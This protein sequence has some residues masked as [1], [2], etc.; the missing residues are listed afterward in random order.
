M[1][2]ISMKGISMTIH[3]RV[4]K[5]GHIYA[6]DDK[7]K[8]RIKVSLAVRSSVFRKERLDY[9]FS[10]EREKLLQ[11]EQDKKLLSLDDLEF[12]GTLVR[13]YKN[14]K[15]YFE[16]FHQPLLKLKRKNKNGF[17]YNRDGQEKKKYKRVKVLFKAEGKNFS[18]VFSWELVRMEKKSL[19]EW[20]KS[21]Y[22]SKLSAV[23]QKVVL[24][25]YDMKFVEFLGYHA[26]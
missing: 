18:D 5:R 9:L 23:V 15:T 19:K 22:D 26:I 13:V 8:K 2:H 21:I 14:K 7:K 10:I 4:N 25:K 17:F 20:N 11:Y 16:K 24:D 1:I 3:A 6:Y 12:P